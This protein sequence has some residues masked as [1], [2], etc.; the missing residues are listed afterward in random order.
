[1]LLDG[2]KI[3][4]KI[5]DQIKKTIEL[6]TNKKPGLAVVLVGNNPA[7]CLYVKNKRKACQDVGIESTFIHLSE[8]IDE[9][10]L[11]QEI[12]KLNC[13]PLVHG[14][15]V[16]FPLPSHINCTSIV[17]SINPNKDVDCFHPLNV[18]K[19]ALGYPAFLPCTPGGIQLLLDEYNIETHSK[20]VVILGR[21]NLVG[22]PLALLLSQ[23]AKGGNASVTLLH[24]HSKK[25]KETCRQADIIVAA[26][27]I[28]NFLKED[29][30]RQSAVVIDVGINRLDGKI[31]GDV[32]FEP[33]APKCSFITPVPG[34]V[35][36]MTIT[37]LLKNT[38]KSFYNHCHPLNP[39]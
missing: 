2:K 1:M 13:D 38:L 36:P 39:T 16:Q 19:L 4:L 20:N 18:G 15:L 12:E 5:R 21:S 11:I 28:P 8:S 32:D 24:S 29:Y 25:I 31:I 22:K 17:E 14:I 9:K 23:K 3:S 37:M 34:G 26:I 6:E 10:S 7:S 35:G 27:G 30:V 33:V